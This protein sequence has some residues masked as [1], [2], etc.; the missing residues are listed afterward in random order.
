MTKNYTWHKIADSIEEISFSSTGLAEVHVNGKT[1]CVAIKD[2]KLQACAQK[3]PHAGALMVD[4]YV[5]AAGNIVCALHR[6]KFS[7]QSGRNISG[8]GY[9]L[10]IFPIE[11]RPEGIFVGIADAGLFNWLK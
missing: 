5:D 2:N 7:L 9:F 11:T 10:K 1:I 8:E 3:C 6:Y 4:G